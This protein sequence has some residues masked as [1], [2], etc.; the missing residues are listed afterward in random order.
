MS[1]SI[2]YPARYARRSA[3]EGGSRR[4]CA[5]FHAESTRDGVHSH[6]IGLI[7]RFIEYVTKGWV[8]VNASPESVHA[9]G[10]IEVL[11]GRIGI[12]VINALHATERAIELAK[13]HGM[14]LVA[15]CDT[16]H[17]GSFALVY[18]AYHRRAQGW[19]FI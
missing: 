9:L 17:A 16:T 13:E 6:G 2:R 15:L 4:V 19:I 14:R 11:D 5:R 8:D 10:A 1:V 7:P 3:V 18:R 12:G